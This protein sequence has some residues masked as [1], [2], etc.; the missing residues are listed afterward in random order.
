[1]VRAMCGVLLKDRNKY[2]D[3]MLMLG[4]RETIDQWAMTNSVCMLW[5]CVVEGGWS[6]LEKGI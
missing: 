4:L 5:S 3:L 6:H 1:M 2:T